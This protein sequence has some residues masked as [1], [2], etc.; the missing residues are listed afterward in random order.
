MIAVE[1]GS[2]CG[3]YPMVS[4]I[5]PVKNEA[6][7]I[8]ACLE[9]ILATDY[10]KNCY[11]I[12]LVDNGSTDDTAQIAT[13]LGVKVFVRP[14]LTISGLRN[15]GA[16]VAVGEILA[17]VDADIVV[18]KNWLPSVVNCINHSDDIGCVGCVPSPPAEYGWVAGTWWLLEQP[19]GTDSG[20]QVGWLP[21]AN[22]AVK[23]RA[24]ES[25]GGF[26]TSLVTCEDVDFCYRL[27]TKYKIVYCREM[28]AIHCGAIRSL[29]ELFRKELW[30]G[31][32][33]YAGVK[34]HGIRI[35]ELPSLLLPIYYL[36][37]AIGFILSIISSNWGLLT[38]NLICWF[39]PPII[40][41]YLAASR[42]SKLNLFPE[43]VSCYLVYCLAR[44]AALLDWVIGKGRRRK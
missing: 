31:G 24:F 34:I 38:V 40:K 6:K 43:M 33:N 32:S 8:V 14:E 12:I 10:P 4:V 36:V 17:F 16:S 9:S 15:F 25:V 11:E 1:K 5:I 7:R 29:A 2:H 39:L 19:P 22:I 13:G 27:G 21:S 42:N 37:L 23:K 26:D 18:S 20:D 3:I 28:G 35:D 30:R 44:S 41:S